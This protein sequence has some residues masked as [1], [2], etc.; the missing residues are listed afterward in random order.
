[1]MQTILQ[2]ASTAAADAA[3]AE[4][5]ICDGLG[6]LEKLIENALKPG[7]ENEKFRRVRPG[8]A[9]L[10]G[11]LELL[12]SLT[13]TLEEP[14]SS[15]SPSSSSTSG[16][17]PGRHN[18]NR[19]SGSSSSSND[20]P[21]NSLLKRVGFRLVEGDALVWLRPR[22][23]AERDLTLLRRHTADGFKRFKESV[24]NVVKKNQLQASASSSSSSGPQ[25]VAQ[26][27]AGLRG[28]RSRKYKEAQTQAVVEYLSKHEEAEDISG[29]D[30]VSLLNKKAAK[31]ITCTRCKQSLRYRKEDTELVLC[32]C[33]EILV[34][35]YH[36]VAR[37]R[38]ISALPEAGVPVDPRE[39]KVRG[40]PMV[41]ISSSSESGDS[42]QRL[43]PLH[44]ILTAF[45]SHEET[46]TQEASQEEIAALPKRML[47]KTDKIE[48]ED[49]RACRICMEDFFDESEGPCPEE[50]EVRT[51]PCLHFFHTKC[52]DQWLAVNK[53][54]PTCRHEI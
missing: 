5:E 43:M 46:R 12:A 16:P 31:Y 7:S 51:L 10:R 45:Q 54:C 18:R 6:T 30:V 11:K 17:V 24:A 40:G 15:A 20:D 29:V 37:G 26:Q 21:I 28:E 13:M 38:V 33:G 47:R 14:S 50:V 41:A 48:N 32:V 23:E 2:S 8:N 9:A 25:T 3:D 44:S 19:S 4:T 27:L 1:M 52:I 22:D 34:V 42:Q 39:A 53:V 35:D 49:N 36:K